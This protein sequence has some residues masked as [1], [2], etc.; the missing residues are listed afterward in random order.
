MD[1]KVTIG[2]WGAKSPEQVIEKIN[3]MFE[4]YDLYYHFE[5]DGSPE[6]N[7]LDGEEGEIKPLNNK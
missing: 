4:A 1:F 6:I 5:E 7:W 2:V 3:A